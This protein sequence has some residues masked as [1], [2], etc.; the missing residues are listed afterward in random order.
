VPLPPELVPPDAQVEIEAKKA[1]GYFTPETVVEDLGCV[2]GR[3]L[4]DY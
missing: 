2:V 4:K 3:D 1:A